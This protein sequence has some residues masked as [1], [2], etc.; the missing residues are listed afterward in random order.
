MY[1]FKV[2]PVSHCAPQCPTM[3]LSHCVHCH[4]CFPP[5][6]LCQL[7]L[8]FLNVPPY[9][10][11]PLFLPLCLLVP[12][13]V[14]LYPPVYSAP[15]C[16]HYFNLYYFFQCVNCSQCVRSVY[17]FTASIGFNCVHCVPLCL[18]CPKYSEFTSS[19]AST[20]YSLC[21]VHGHFVPLWLVRSTVTTTLCP[22]C[23]SV[24]TVPCLPSPMCPL[25][26]ML[27]PLHWPMLFGY[28]KRAQTLLSALGQSTFQLLYNLYTCCT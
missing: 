25:W 5:C 19:T 15:L 14:S 17:F 8:S 22:I 4:Y 23:P 3:Y 2:D 6:P 11:C 7:C 24:P 28:S 9:Q 1:C 27:C 26:P 16:V 10:L 13:C 21:N 18:L 20:F 12:H